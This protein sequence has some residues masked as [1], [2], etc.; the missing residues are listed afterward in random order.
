MP[1]SRDRRRWIDRQRKTVEVIKSVRV[2]PEDGQRQP[3]GGQTGS[4]TGSN[5][6]AVIA[7]SDRSPLHRHHRHL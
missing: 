4:Q 3:A 6:L 5:V 1:V 2:E 7:S